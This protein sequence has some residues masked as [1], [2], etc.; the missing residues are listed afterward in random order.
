VN[1][2]DIA[3]LYI[4]NRWANRR[5]LGSVRP[6]DHDEF[7]R[8][9]GTSHGSV[10]GTLVH[11]MW[12]EWVWL[13]R[14]HG[15]SPKRIFDE[16]DFADLAAVTAYWGDLDDERAGFIARLTDD[17][18]DQ[19]ITY[20]NAKNQRWTY[21]LGHMMQ[22]VVNHSTYHRGQIVT[23]LR[24]LGHAPAPTDFLVLFDEGGEKATL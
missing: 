4:Y 23:L 22:H 21:T 2:K 14:W 7:T 11:T 19:S 6:L 20:E 15:E 3:T 8:D 1:T 16:G 24:Q 18:L 12:A 5:A 10:R 13:R 17:R 9:L